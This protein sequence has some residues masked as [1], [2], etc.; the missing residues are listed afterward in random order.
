ML[1]HTTRHLDK[2]LRQRGMDRDDLDLLYRYGTEV[3][4]GIYLRDRDVSTAINYHKSLI[5]RLER[6]RNTYVVQKCDR[7]FTAYNPT[8]KKKTRILR[9]E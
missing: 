4:D 3:K 1:P 8:G 7:I 6:I 5:Q 2:R 9:T